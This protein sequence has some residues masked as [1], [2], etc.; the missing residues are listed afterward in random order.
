[1]VAQQT[2]RTV[3][4]TAWF[5][6]LCAGS[7]HLDNNGNKSAGPDGVT[8]PA[9]RLEAPRSQRLPWPARCARGEWRG[10][11]RS[12]CRAPAG[13]PLASPLPPWLVMKKREEDS[14]SPLSL[15][16]G[17]P[18]LPTP[19]SFLTSCSRPLP[20]FRAGGLRREAGEGRPGARA[21][22]WA[23]R[24]EDRLPWAA[25]GG[26]PGT[27]PPPLSGRRRRDPRGSFFSSRMLQR[28]VC[29]VGDAR[30]A[31]DLE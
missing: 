16:L 28:R 17:L 26:G 11:G 29:A 14:L 21:R 15:S 25:S 12:G 19:T 10:D 27:P 1:M 31:L 5:C 20:E 8:P 3:D 4:I 18:P 22:S 2:Q 6:V 30:P 13:G 24:R 9:V 23:A 7:L